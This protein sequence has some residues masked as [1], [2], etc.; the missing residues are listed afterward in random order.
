MSDFVALHNY[1]LSAE[2]EMNAEFLR[3]AGIPAMLQGPQP[4]FFGPGFSGASVQ[5]VTLMVP[6]EDV[7]RAREL[8]DESEF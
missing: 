3:A 8:L 5:G 2:A 6:A 7:E 4:G 1:E